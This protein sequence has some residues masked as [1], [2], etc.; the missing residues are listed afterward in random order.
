[1]SERPV[2]A[3]YLERAALHY[4]ERYASSAENLRRVLTRKARRR[5]A[6]G[7]SLTD[8]MAALIEEVV[9]R[10]IRSGLVDDRSYAETRVNS[11]MR[12]GASTRA[13]RTKL[14]AKG[15]AGETIATALGAAEPD[16]FALARRY[17]ER[18][19]LGPWR[20][21]PG[22]E[23]HEKDLAALCR[24]GFSYRIASAVLAASTEND[25]IDP[26]G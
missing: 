6:P 12:R 20:R 10:V 19:R 22:P 18:K 3:A 14:L 25:G 16:E 7:E 21:P 1:M 24:A 4:L 5:L 2:T 17:A 9:A 13:I 23:T 8:E 11:L 26:G 15:V